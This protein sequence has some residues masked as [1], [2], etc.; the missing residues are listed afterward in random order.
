MIYVQILNSNNRFYIDSFWLSGLQYFPLPRL[1]VQHFSGIFA[2]FEPFFQTP[3][4]SVF[5]RR[6]PPT[7]NLLV[8]TQSVPNGTIE[9]IYQK[10]IKLHNNDSQTCLSHQLLPNFSL[11][12]RYK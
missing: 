5:H 4:N 9:I 11:Q 6:H 1:N 3:C 12:L 10:S 7:F 2:P 8:S